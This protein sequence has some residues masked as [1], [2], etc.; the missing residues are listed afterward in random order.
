MVCCVDVFREWVRQGIAG[1]ESRLI[2]KGGGF[3]AALMA[4]GGNVERARLVEGL[5]SLRG[6]NL[7]CWCR[8]DQPC[9]AD[10]LLEIGNA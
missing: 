4:A 9:H 5:P 6:K 2:G 8:L 7:A 1:E 3:R 10:V